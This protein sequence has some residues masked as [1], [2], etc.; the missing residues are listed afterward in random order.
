[1]RPK[2]C[3]NMIVK[4]E[5]AR[6]TRCLE[7][8]APY[9][10]YWVIYDTGS[11]D[12]TVAL[13]EAFF[14]GRGIPGE[15]HRGEFINFEQARNAALS[16]ARSSVFPWDYLLL[17][18]ADMELVVTN[19]NFRDGLT[20]PAYDVIQKGGTL[21]Y[22]N[23]RL[24]ARSTT[25]RYVG[26]THEYLDIPCN[27][28]LHEIYF[29]DHADGTNRKDKFKRD[30]MLLL[31]ALKKDPSNARYQFYLAQSYSDNGNHKGAI[32]A[33]RKRIKMGGW[34]E[35][36]YISHLKLSHSLLATGDDAGFIRTLLDAYNLR[37][38]RAE[39]PW[40]LAHYYRLK[41]K[42]AA[43]V[44]FSE[45][46]LSLP[47]PGDSLF[48]NRYAHTVG[49]REEF[50]ICAFY[51]PKKRQHGFK[52]CNDLALDQ[53]EYKNARELARSNL[54]HYL[55]PLSEAAPSFQP[56]RLEFT[57][58]DTVTFAPTGYALLNPSVTLVNTELYVVIRTVN[59]DIDKDGRYLIKHTETGEITND[60]PIHTRNYL[61][62]LSEKLEI[63][64]VS[65]ILPPL[66]PKPEYP[67]VVGF[68]DMRLFEFQ[69]DMWT[70][71]T[72]RELNREGWCEQVLAKIDRSTGQ[73]HIVEWHK[74]DDTSVR[75]HEKNWM[76]WI[77]DGAIRFAYHVNEVVDDYGRLVSKMPLAFSADQ[78]RGGSQ[79]IPFHGGWLALIH[80]AGQ[81]DNKR[82]YQHRFVWFCYNGLIQYV[83]LPFVF[84][85]KQIE[86]AAGLAWHPDEKRL[87]ISYGVADKEAWVATVDDH[88][89]MEM[90]H[91]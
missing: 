26:V 58:C 79:V 31:N 33:Y 50:S 27:D 74:M 54:L 36:L 61:A 43:S 60:N 87:V 59:Y 20:A 57:P 13:I 35:E 10:D 69:G 68:E 64:T 88:D 3:L 25:G 45:P 85:A 17:A 82:Y 84:H 53:T 2:I 5:A 65:E 29:I 89:I 70:S 32:T 63:Q 6:I 21:S 28:H 52:V 44:L 91:P 34:D 18:D 66:L 47:Y 81:L 41:G 24:I 77:K 46:L 30:I 86:F 15:T 11:S 55:K 39:A 38:S 16:C 72:M 80:E 42:N 40:E 73:P 48:V 51:D 19:K 8:V 37:P 9:I 67:L 49:L 62:K 83:S 71:S 4:N 90:L 12:N 14:D 22:A 7:S 76:P 56:R 23:R 78:F 1:V 75:Q